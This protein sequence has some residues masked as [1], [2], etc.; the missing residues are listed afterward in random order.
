MFVPP[1]AA[2]LLI[3]HKCNLSCRHCSVYSHGEL[4]GE[5]SP[6]EWGTILDK[7]AKAKLFTLT[8]TGGEPFMRED[9]PEVFR[10][11]LKRPFRVNINT[12][13]TL[14]TDEIAE[15]LAGAMP[16]FD[17]V[18]VSLDGDSP[19]IHDAIRGEGVFEKTMDGIRILKSAKVPIVFY[20]TV[21]ALNINRIEQITE[22]AV[23]FGEYIKFNT[24]LDTGPD[25]DSKL[26]P[27]TN[28]VKQAGIAVMNAARK[29]P[30]RV[31][32]TLLEMAVQAVK[33]NNG[34]AERFPSSKVCGAV[35]SKIAVFPN[36]SVT[37]CDH[38]PDL[39]LGNLLDSDLEEILT[40]RR[41]EYFKR[42]TTMRRWPWA[43]CKMC[44]FHNYCSGPCPAGAPIEGASKE[45]FSLFCLKNYLMEQ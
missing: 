36:G 9:F 22:L 10:E 42:V 6:A 26:N 33:A 45:K 14:I 44:E 37:P 1:R 24:F 38:L 27:T 13:A 30:Y 15:V 25:T 2:N 20:C 16:R 32:G 18:M 19:A 12:N 34:T 43:E 11:V 3:T 4:P 35:S 17:T 8:L 39:N 29:Y 21:N 7:L 5:L 23:K 41:A 31:S 28:T 40:G